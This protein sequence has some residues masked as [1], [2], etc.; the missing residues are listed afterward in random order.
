MVSNFIFHYEDC[1]H[2][3]LLFPYVMLKGVEML[4]RGFSLVDEVKALRVMPNE[5]IQDGPSLL[6]P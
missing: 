6:Y 3:T 1:C 5:T 2:R 4:D